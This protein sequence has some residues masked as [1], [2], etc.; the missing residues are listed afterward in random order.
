MSAFDFSALIKHPICLPE[1]EK[2]ANLFDICFVHEG[3]VVKIS[4]ALFAL[5][6]QDVA[7]ISVFAFNFP[8]AGEREAL[9]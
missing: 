2:F 3:C 1:V 6:R 8:C 7:V 4:L 5:L 9:L